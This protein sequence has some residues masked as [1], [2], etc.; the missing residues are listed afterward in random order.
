MPRPDYIATPR[1]PLFRRRTRRRLIIAG[2]ASACLI[3]LVLVAARPARNAIR[4]WQSRKHA[5]RALAFIDEQK[6]SNARDEATAAYQL[7]PNEPEA[8]RAVARLLSRIGQIDGLEFWKKLSSIESL[9]IEDLRDEA[10]IALKGND[11][12]TA[13]DAVQRL[14]NDHSHK[15]TVV[16]YLLAAEVATRRHDYRTTT[17]YDQ[18]VLAN[19]DATRAEQLR[20]V[21]SLDTIVR[22]GGRILVDDPK[23]IDQR[24]LALASGDD[25]ASLD[26]LTALAQ[27]ALAPDGNITGDLPMPL[28]DFITKI[29]NHPK[30]AIASHLMAND[31]EIAQDKNKL[32]QIQQRAVDRWKD[33]STEDVAM[34]GAWLYRQGQYQRELEVI[35]L[36]RAVQTRELF[37]ER[38]DALAALQRWNEITKLLESERYPLD[39]VI[40]SMYLALACAK[41]GAQISANNNW[42]RAIENAAGDLSKLLTLA[43]F[44]ERNGFGAVAATAYDAA[45]AVSPKS[46]NAQL[47]RLRA[48]RANGDTRK[49]YSVVQE[50]LKIWPNDPNLQNDEMYLRLL[51]L[52]RG[53]APNSTELRSIQAAA[54]KLVTEQPNS[55]PHRTVLAL[56]LLRQNQ[57]YTAL[58]VYRNLAVARSAVTPS[59]IAIR[60]A[61]LQACGQ[62]D[63]AKAEAAKVQGDKLLPEEKELIARF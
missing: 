43:S 47:G 4:A 1:K 5:E 60:A 16:D 55:F 62:T 24:L 15:D 38:I 23:R 39:P 35:S 54:E 22:S 46:L 8:L 25:Q 52:P 59:T 3:L 29:K 36:N 50:L 30:A 41:Q 13:N 34:L 56:A 14:L 53:S 18:Q 37:L 33:S 10:R 20:A 17:D 40:Q 44:A 42:Q 31:L 57:P 2:I 63:E 19:P 27:R 6:W 11:L 7:R 21:L 12:A 28:P 26:A 51:L 9:T 58:S 61:V 45:V 48:M 49:I 32:E